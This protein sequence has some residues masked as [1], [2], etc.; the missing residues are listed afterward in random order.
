MSRENDLLADVCRAALRFD[1]PQPALQSAAEII[2]SFFDAT[3]VGFVFP[4][5][6]RN[7]SRLEAFAT[8]GAHDRL[9]LQEF[10]LASLMGLLPDPDALRR[11]QIVTLRADTADLPL[12]AREALAIISAG[13]V[14]AVRMAPDG[15]SL[16]VALLAMA[17]GADPLPAADQ[18]ILINVLDEVGRLFRHLRL[19]QRDYSRARRLRDLEVAMERMPD[20]FKIFS[21]EWRIR[22]VNPAAESLLGY[23][24]GQL[25]GKPAT[26]ELVSDDRAGQA[27]IERVVREEG[28]WRGECVAESADGA[29]VPVRRTAVAV[30]DDEGQLSAV[31]VIDRD[32]REEKEAQEQLLQAQR[33]ASM[34]QL[35]AAVSHEVSNPLAIISGLAQLL[36]M[37]DLAEDLAED[38]AAIRD[39]T[40]RAAA[41]LHDLLML[42]AVVEP[43]MRSLDFGEA[44]EGAVRLRRHALEAEGIRVDLTIDPRTPPVMADPVQITH[45]L[46]HLLTNARQAIELGSDSGTVRILVR[47]SGSRAELVVEDTGPGIQEDMLKSIFA[48]FVS[49]KGWVGSGLGLSVCREV[50]QMHGG[51]ITAENWGEPPVA[52]AKP[53]AGGARFVVGLPSTARTVEEDAGGEAATAPQPERALIV[54]HEPEIAQVMQRG[55]ERISCQAE[56]VPS[57][58][59]ALRKLD[60]GEE[61]DVILCDIAAESM[62]GPEFYE[63]LKDRRS[64]LAD[65]LVFHSSR[66]LGAGE[67]RFLEKTQRPLLTRPFS[68]DA[69][70]DAVTR[71]MSD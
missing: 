24:A 36:L 40:D 11:N 16:G 69:L 37:D 61:F 14:Y 18:R 4:R 33:L 7:A 35:A 3:A 23:S 50:V 13:T 34:G 43:D 2:R 58:E 62:G 56:V 31:L 48:P 59:E 26:F 46:H 38:L 67:R 53:G 70:G 21:P 64:R 49:T 20:P 25:V 68:L 54:D 22:Y 32:L 17:R 19:R 9:S 47:R 41:I 39:A 44:V 29:R 55:L 15:H 12:Q 27:G 51:E 71:A 57:A 8:E 63:R 30:R 28:V 45:L 42:S 52:G 6:R 10:E 5:S 1:A 66:V 65:R 60:A